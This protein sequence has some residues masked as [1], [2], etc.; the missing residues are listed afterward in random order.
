MRRKILGISKTAHRQIMQHHKP[1]ANSI[2]IKTSFFFQFITTPTSDTPGTAILVHF[3]NKRYIFGEVVEGTQRATIQL[4][5]SLKKVRGLFLT[6]K[7]AWSNGGLLGLILSLSEIQKEDI[8]AKDID[9]RPRMD[10]YG[11]PKQLHSLACA[12]RFIFRTGMPLSVHE[13]TPGPTSQ[14]P[15]FEDENIRVWAIATKLTL[16]GSTEKPS[17]DDSDFSD[18][19]SERLL[20]Y[21]AN[22]GQAHLEQGLRRDVVNNM[23]DSKWRTN[24]VVR[25]KLGEV[26]LPARV[27]VKDS[28]TKQLTSRAILSLD[29]IA[30][31][32]LETEVLVRKPWPASIVEN[33]P[34]PANLPHHVSMSYIVKGHPQRGKFDPTKAKALGLRPGPVFAKL[35]AGE[36]V[37]SDTGVTVTPEM[38]MGPT[39]PSK[40]LAIFDLP[41]SAYLP[42]LERQIDEHPSLLDGVET[43][44]WIFDDNLV[45]TERFRRLLSR[46]NEVRHVFSHPHLCKDHIV[47]QSSAMSMQRL[48]KIAP[49]YFSTPRFNRETG[50]TTSRHYDPMLANYVGESFER[51]SQAT[52][53]KRGRKMYIEPAFRVDDQEVPPNFDPQQETANLDQHVV[54]LLPKDVV[55]QSPEIAHVHQAGLT[56]PEIITLGTGSSLPS[57]YRNV[58]AVMLR[59]PADMG[60]YLFDCGEGTL[61]QLR[62]MF[63]GHQ[64]D[65]IL[66][67]LKAIWISHLHADHH[68]GLA[69]LLRAADLARKRRARATH[70]LILPPPMLISDSKIIMYMDEYSDILGRKPGQLY[71]PVIC[72]G[73]RAPRLY[74]KICDFKKNGVPIRLLETVRVL[75]CYGALA[76]SVTFDNNFKFSYS[77]DCRPSDHFCEIGQNSDVLVHEATFDDEMQQDAKAKKHSTTG[78]ALG[79]AIKMKAKNLILTHFSQR[80]QKIPVLSNV[81]MPSTDPGELPIDLDDEEQVGGLDSIETEPSKSM[82]PSSSSSS[83][84]S[85]MAKQPMDTNTSVADKL[86]IAIAFDLM[87]IR[88]SQI[89]PMKKYFPAISRMFSLLEEKSEQERQE[90][91]ATDHPKKPPKEEAKN[92]NPSGGKKQLAKREK[93]PKS[94]QANA[95]TKRKQKKTVVTDSAKE[96]QTGDLAKPMSPK[97]KRS[98]SGSPVPAISADGGTDQTLGSPPPSP[99]GKKRKVSKDESAT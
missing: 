36:S 95:T 73:H 42:E 82:R 57:K 83:S 74:G 99:S 98:E 39:T 7:T 79:V 3:D 97:K 34:P 84:P 37:Q 49:G 91:A 80:Y 52:V 8:E 26:N 64:L 18:E 72:N 90:R 87:R 86:P 21:D 88:V 78:E 53:A 65:Q 30:P 61:G 9:Q 17:F 51:G 29:N 69:M 43:C 40:G 71:E 24:E 6:G 47:H 76:V 10:V 33:L 68:L 77:G 35:A 27:W 12:R 13:A 48:S 22:D 38:V 46:L 20:N 16:P 23:F 5:I 94:Q 25:L 4:G 41:S 11:G 70:K 75:H 66:C 55:D 81:K 89:A 59:M 50:Y 44:V 67:D 32:T 96:S 54:D 45:G 31:L 1:V 28:E 60:N 56:E 15:D 62:R 2:G 19:E 63:D 58:S 14:E 85:D 92:P 93:D